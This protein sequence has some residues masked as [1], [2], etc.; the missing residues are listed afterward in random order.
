M[1]KI[2]ISNFLNHKPKNLP[3]PMISELLKKLQ[4]ICTTVKN[5]YHI[6]FLHPRLPT[7]ILYEEFLMSFELKNR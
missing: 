5:N 1:I 3:F 4:F 6:R 2:E 7:D